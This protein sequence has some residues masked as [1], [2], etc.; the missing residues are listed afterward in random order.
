MFYRKLCDVIYIIKLMYISGNVLP[1]SQTHN[2]RNKKT[3]VNQCKR[4]KQ[5]CLVQIWSDI[6]KRIE[7][8]PE[9]SEKSL[10]ARVLVNNYRTILKSGPKI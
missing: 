9:T 8:Y 3:T 2:N 6:F 7:S 4:G 1:S 5:L 10:V